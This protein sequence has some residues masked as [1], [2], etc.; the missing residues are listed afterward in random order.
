MT[1]RW[2]PARPGGE[3]HWFEPL[4][5]HLGSAYL[6]Y[7]FTK[8]TENEVDFLWDV[9]DLHEG[10]RVLDVGCGPGRH[11]LAMAARGAEVVGIDISHRFIDIADSKAPANATF[12]R[13]DA[14]L[15]DFDADFDV[16]ISLC[17]GAFGLNRRSDATGDSSVPPPGPDP[18]AQVL[19][20]MTRALRPGG[21]LALTAFS[22][23]F[24]V[25]YLDPENDFDA[26][27]GVN[28]ERTSLLDED[29]QE[30]DADLW[31]TCWTP[32]ELRSLAREVGLECEHIWSVSPGDYLRR[33][34]DIEHPEYLMMARRGN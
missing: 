8:G 15:L 13:R 25:R 1:N 18:D 3:D 2:G 33:V 27:S 23:Y 5:D 26:A 4:A 19:G 21:A 10:I 12:L 20:G 11:A 28:L 31:T 6:R 30:L 22:A 34:P 29:G 24:Q 14:R 9:L 32:R 7:S 17:Q 16:A